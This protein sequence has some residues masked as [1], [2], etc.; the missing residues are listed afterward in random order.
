LKL[1]GSAFAVA[2]VYGGILIF[3]FHITTTVACILHFE[4]FS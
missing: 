2:K 4:F 3:G 1:I